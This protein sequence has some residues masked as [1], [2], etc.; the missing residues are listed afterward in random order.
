MTAQIFGRA[1]H[2][3]VRTQFKRT[4]V[5]RRGEGVVDGD[6]CAVRMRLAGHG[7]DIDDVQRRIRPRFEEHQLHAV[8]EQGIQ[9]VT[10]IAQDAVCAQ[11]EAGQ[12]LLQQ[13]QLAAIGVTDADDACAAVRQEQRAQRRH[14]GREHP[15][16]L[17]RLETG[18]R[19]LQRV[20]RRVQ[21]VTCVQTAARAAVDHI[22]QVGRRTETE[23]GGVVDRRVGTTVG[24]IGGVAVNRTGGEKILSGVVH[25]RLPICTSR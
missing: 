6:Q 16:G 15:R 5:H 24:V 22:E 20:D 19:L 2:D 11:P 8:S 18:E 7:A 4:L 13:F 9:P 25:Q 1:V 14:A 17:G 23:G 12:L 3:E 21:P 10:L